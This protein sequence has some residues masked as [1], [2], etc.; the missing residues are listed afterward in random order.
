MADIKRIF[1][2]RETNQSFSSPDRQSVEQVEDYAVKK[3]VMTQELIVNGVSISGS[4]SSTAP[5]NYRGTDFTGSN[6]TKTLTHVR[7]LPQSCMLVIGGRVMH[8]DLE[9]TIAGTQITMVDVAI[10]DDDYVMVV[11]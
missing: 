11:E 10:F 9:Y 6:P 5:T 1:G 8:R 4:G 7:T 2:I 3:V